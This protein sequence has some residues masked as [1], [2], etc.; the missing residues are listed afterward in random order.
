VDVNRLLTAITE[1]VVGMLQ[2]IGGP[3]IGR[4]ALSECSTDD[5]SR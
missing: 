4:L 1:E 3:G 5:G 2:R